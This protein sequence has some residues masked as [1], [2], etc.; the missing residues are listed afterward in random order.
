MNDMTRRNAITI[1]AAGMVSFAGPT[2]TAEGEDLLGKHWNDMW[3]AWAIT[4]GTEAK[5][6]VEGVYVRGGP[7][8]VAILKPAAP[9]GINPKILLLELNIGQLPGVWPAVL[10]PIPAC[11]TQAPYKK[12]Q[13]ESVQVRYLDGRVESIK[14]IIDAGEGPKAVAEKGK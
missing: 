13:Y 14:Q 9:Q 11:Y 6:T 12:G 4:K 7:G 5:L 3:R 8:L 2:A 1:A 10:V